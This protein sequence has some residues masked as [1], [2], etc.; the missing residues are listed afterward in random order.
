MNLL[1]PFAEDIWTA[2]VPFRA[3]GMAIGHRMT[4]VRLAG[5]ALWVHSPLEWSRQ[6]AGELS[7][8][9]EVRHLIAPNLNHDLWLDSWREKSRTALLWGAPGLREKYSG[10]NIHITADLTNEPHPEWSGVLDQ[11]L[12][13]G[14]PKVNEVVFF[15]TPSQ[16][17]IVADLVFNLRGKLDFGTSV[18]A[19]LN[20]CSK[21]MAVTRLFR[22]AI[23]DRPLF[24]QSMRRVLS[25]ECER[26]IVGHGEIAT[27]GAR[28][29]LAMAFAWLPEAFPNGSRES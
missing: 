20:G 29:L 10:S 17:L 22:S 16:S 4:V 3:G 14:M 19:S 26:I 8:L 9:G 1:Q 25:W 15:H 23:K 24:A 11:V 12:I 21:G 2:N 27:N 5:N 6:L 18:L 13:Q 28:H 7:E